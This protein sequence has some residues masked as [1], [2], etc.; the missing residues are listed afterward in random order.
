MIVALLVHGG[1]QGVRTTYIVVDIVVAAAR[2]QGEV[3]GEG[4]CRVKL[5][6]YY[7]VFE[8]KVFCLLRCREDCIFWGRLPKCA[9]GTT[10]QYNTIRCHTTHIAIT[11]ILYMTGYNT[12]QYNMIPDAVT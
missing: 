12:M 9:I 2:S 6:Y 1:T 8:K 11:T 7:I 5:Y 10:S 3:R 4:V